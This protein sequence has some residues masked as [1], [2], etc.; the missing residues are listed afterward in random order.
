MQYD[1]K[2]PNPDLGVFGNAIVD[3][4]LRRALVWL[5]AEVTAYYGPPLVHGANAIP[6]QV[7]LRILLKK[8]RAI[9]HEDDLEQ[10]ETLE[11]GTELDPVNGTTRADTFGG[12]LAISEYPPIPRAIVMRP[13]LGSTCRLRGPIPIGT[14]GVALISSRMIDRWQLRSGVVDP[15]FPATNAH[16]HNLASCVFLPTATPGASEVGDQEGV[17]AYLGNDAGS[18]SI[19]W[20]SDHMA[21]ES[22]DLRLGLD[23]ATLGVARATDP[24]GIHAALATWMGNVQAALNGL[25]APIAALVGTQIGTITSGSSNVKTI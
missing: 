6:A 15:D 22:T 8:G 2:I 16:L 10:G 1:D 23:S 3:E 17:D 21:I 18:R 13:G 9:E 25:G 14:T 7:T 5:P 19:K 24:V 12:R 20:F 4:A 11:L